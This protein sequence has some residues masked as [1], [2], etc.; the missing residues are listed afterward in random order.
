ML[1]GLLCTIPL[2]LPSPSLCRQGSWS[3]A[4]GPTPMLKVFREVS[5]WPREQLVRETES[6]LPPIA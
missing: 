4:R 5:E 6:R 2:G 1:L 3:P